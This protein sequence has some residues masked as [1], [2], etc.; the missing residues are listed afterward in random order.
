M[1]ADLS[2]QGAEDFLALSKRLKATGQLELRKELNKGLRRAARPL[3][4]KAR[5]AART[6]LPQRGGLATLIGGRPMRVSVRTGSTP[7]V[8]IVA[9]KTDPRID[10]GRVYHPVFGRRPGVV[11]RIRPGFF[12]ETLQREAPAVRDDLLAVLDDITRR[13]ARR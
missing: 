5:S 3:I 7:G 8:S 12:S 4:P 2:V 9:A 6:T 10:A 11:Q 13:V 1:P